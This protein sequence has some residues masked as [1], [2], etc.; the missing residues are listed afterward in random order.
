MPDRTR[1]PSPSATAEARAELERSADFHRLRHA[2][3]HA[4]VESRAHELTAAER[5]SRVRA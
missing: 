4:L 5:D 3:Q 2:E 1:P